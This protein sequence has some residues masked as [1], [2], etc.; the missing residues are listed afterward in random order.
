IDAVKPAAEAKG[1]SLEL[2]LASDLGRIWADGERVQQIA[3]NLLSNAIK[4]TPNR[5]H[6]TLCAHRDERDVILRVCD[7]GQGI[8]PAFLPHVF[9][10]FRQADGSTTRRHGGL[11]LG[12]AIVKQLVHAHGGNV[13]VESPG[14]GRGTTF[15]V[16][17]PIRKAEPEDPTQLLLVAASR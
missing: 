14:A 11:G 10:P 17:L 1:V 16:Q 4:F 2:E 13:H 8:E 3:W 5:G 6:V 7:D 12:L 9:E 15:T